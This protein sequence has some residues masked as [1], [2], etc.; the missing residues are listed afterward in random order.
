MVTKTALELHETRKQKSFNLFIS[1]F[2][3]WATYFDGTFGQHM[4]YERKKGSDGLTKHLIISSTQDSIHS[5]AEIMSIVNAFPNLSS[6][7]S[8]QENNPV[9]VIM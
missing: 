9:I 2:N 3:V 4:K 7:V 8:V 6:F 5:D 1:V